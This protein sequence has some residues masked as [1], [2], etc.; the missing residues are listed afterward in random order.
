LQEAFKGAPPPPVALDYD[1]DATQDAIAKAI[2]ASLS[3]VGIKVDL[4]PKAPRDYDG[5]ALSNEP[6]ILRLGWIANYPSADAILAPLFAT[7]S[8]D[9]LTGYSN[10]AVDA[11]LKSARLESDP[12]RRVELYQQ[13]ESTIMEQ[14][15]VV[16]IA[17]FNVHSVIAK[18]AK[19]VKLNSFG[20]FDA[21]QVRVG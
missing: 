3:Q 13:I 7:D 21:T 6:E 12:G 15:P 19:G 10:P 2:Q 17:Q 1:D 5:F 14:V 8:L 9:N 11:M 16:P 18:R 20:S 4:R